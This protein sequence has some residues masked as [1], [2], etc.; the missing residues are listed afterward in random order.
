MDKQDSLT[1]LA[2]LSQET[3]LDVFRLL[4][5]VGPKGL[6]A[7]DIAERLDAR[8]NT[9]S[10]HLA[11]LN[12]AGLIT[13]QRDGRSVCYAANYDGMRGLINFL[14]MDCCRGAPEVV[15][16]LTKSCA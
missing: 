12:R 5:T 8:Q 7:G 9:M 2:A 6:P 13:R 4:V 3:R 16:P 10:T 11:I 1:A 15:Q 14:M